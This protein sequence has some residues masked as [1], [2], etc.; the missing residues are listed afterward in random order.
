MR[1]VSAPVGGE[2]MVLGKGRRETEKGA[3]ICGIPTT[4][5]N[6]TR[7]LISYSSPD[8]TMKLILVLITDEETEAQGYDLQTNDGQFVFC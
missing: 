5:Q 8:S 2:A 1:V 7:S 6:Q 4:C 3:S